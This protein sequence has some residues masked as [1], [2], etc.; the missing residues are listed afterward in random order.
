MTASEA[1]AVSLK[2]ANVSREAGLRFRA[3]TGSGHELILDDVSGDAGPRPVE[4]LVAALAGCTA[5]DVISI[6]EK[7]RQAVTHYEV[8]VMAEQRAANPRV[9]TRVDDTYVALAR[10]R[11]EKVIVLDYWTAK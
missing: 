3:R 5:M 6:L 8:Q 1:P 2:K 4:L 10:E 9:F 7:K 11:R